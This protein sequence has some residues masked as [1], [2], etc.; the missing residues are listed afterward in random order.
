MAEI[1]CAA[2][3]ADWY[4][5]EARQY[6]DEL[7]SNF[8]HDHPGVI[9][10]F[11]SGTGASAFD[12]AGLFFVDL[13]RFGEGTAS[14]SAKGVIEDVFRLLNVVPLGKVASVSK[15]IVAKVLKFISKFY[16]KAKSGGLCVPIS[17]GKALQ[18]TGQRILVSLDDVLEGMGRTLESFSGEFAQGGKPDQIRRAFNELKVV[19]EELPAR[20]AQS[21]DDIKLFAANTE[22]VIMV[23]LK[24]VFRG[25]RTGHMVLASKVGDKVQIIDR[26]GVY[27]SLEE[28]SRR[29]GSTSPEEFYRLATQTP[30]FIVKN[31]V[32]DPALK[33]RLTVSGMFGMVAVRASMALGFNPDVDVEEIKTKFRDY[34]GSQPPKAPAPAPIRLPDTVSV[35][36]V[37][38]IEGPGIQKKDWLSSIAGQ[39]YGELLLW[40]A[41]WDF[42][43]GTDFTNPNKMY[44]GQRIKI[45]FINEKSP[46]ELAEYRRRGRNWQNEKW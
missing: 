23:P 11:V 18:E 2:D 3:F 28:L 6:T 39:W 9:G 26:T 30:F 46:A 4:D 45:P 8:V 42:N 31:W 22:G 19:F 10:V 15:P 38:T 40:P 17:L 24:R 36:G 13:A 12:A 34:V 1:T 20:S 7:L 37:H 43:K 29:Y 41:L 35:M 32:I 25:N 27:N 21:W 5:G 44:V 33:L 16:W 14:G